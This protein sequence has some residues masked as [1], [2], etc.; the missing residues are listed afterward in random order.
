MSE[1]IANVSI[2]C[3]IFGYDDGNLNILLIRRDKQPELN[4]WSLPGGYIKMDETANDSA[5]RLLNDLTGINQLY[6]SQIDVF[7]A[8]KRYPTRRVISILYCA[9][10]KPEHFKI[11]AGAHAKE[12]KWFDVLQTGLLPFDHNKM[13][14]SALSWLKEEIWRRPILRNLLPNTFP[15]NQMQDLYETILCEPI[16]NR[17]FRK[18][19][20]NQGL[21]E[22]TEHKI[23]G[24]KQRPAYLYRLK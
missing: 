21:V 7:S 6:L 22:K 20:I 11:M 10:I 16:D 5:V 18:K 15:L 17:N 4:R 24:T 2:D 19:V 14:D 8:I 1:N 9:F 12:V 3:A 23:K 13:I